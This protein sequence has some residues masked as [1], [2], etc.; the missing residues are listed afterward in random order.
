MKL[1]NQI[2]QAIEVIAVQFFHKIIYG[3]TLLLATILINMNYPYSP[4]H[5]TF[6]NIFLVDDA[7]PYVDAVSARAEAS[8]KSEAILA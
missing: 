2:M 1:G 8:N 4:R 6:M 3:V 5:I 7:N